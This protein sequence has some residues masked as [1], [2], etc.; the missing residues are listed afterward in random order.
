MHCRG[1]SQKGHLPPLG[2]ILSCEQHWW[3]IGPG[4]LKMTLFNLGHFI[5]LGVQNNT[6][7]KVAKGKDPEQLVN[8]GKQLKHHQPQI[9]HLKSES[10]IL[11]VTSLAQIA[12]N[13]PGVNLQMILIQLT[14]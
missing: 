6:S 10:A 14:S 2:V 13:R 12:Q 5:M 1:E 8:L 9:S 3:V 4:Q 11:V 7:L